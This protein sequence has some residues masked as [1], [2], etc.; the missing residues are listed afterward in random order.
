MPTRACAGSSKRPEARAAGA[1]A[2]RQAVTGLGGAAADLCLV[3]ATTGYATAEVLAGIRDVTGSA[4]LV[5]CSAEG[6]IVGGQSDESYRVVGVLALQSTNLRFEPLLVP[7]FGDDPAK[8]GREL[9]AAVRAGWTGDE[10]ALLLLPDGIRGDATALLQELDHGLP[11]PLPV[12]GG[13]AGDALELARTEQFLDGE[14][15]SGAVA[16]LVIRGR[17]RIAVATSHGCQPIGIRRTV[18]AA[19]GPWVLRIDGEPAWAVFRQYLDGEPTRLDTEGAIYLS[20]GMPV[21]GAPEGAERSLRIR[22]PMGLDPERGALCFPGGDLQVGTSLHLM[23]RD[24]DRIRETAQACA[25]ELAR[26]LH[27]APAVVFQFDCA[28]RGKQLFGSRAAEVLVQPLRAAFG[29]LVPW[30]GFHTYGE[31]APVAG[32]NCYHNYTVALC[33]LLDEP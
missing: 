17:G 27:R 12:V 30:F 19:N 3:F 29:G 28:G 22:T 16:A 18:T 8:T 11:K 32:A 33:A 24:Q 6:V 5:G 13:G 31:I 23:R 7:G 26:G 9:A 4:R 25:E 21:A 1:E 15:T 20:V 10:I 2:A 14:V